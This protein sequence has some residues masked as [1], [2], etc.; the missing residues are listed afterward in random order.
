MKI[1]SKNE[2]IEWLRLHNIDFSQWG[3]ESAKSIEDLWHEIQMGESLIQDDPPCRVVLGVVRL[4]ICQEDRILIETKQE[5]GKN[6]CRDRNIPPSEKLKP[7]ESYIECAK[8]CLREE[9]GIEN[10]DMEIIESTY[11][12]KKNVRNSQSYPG[13]DTIYNNHKFKAIVNGLPKGSF[14]TFE[15]T[16][17][18]NNSIKKHYWTWIR[19]DKIDFDFI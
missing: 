11:S 8:R 3:R 2:L 5:F 7:L 9:L 15:S 17:K 6:Q 10:G 12:Q 14:S 18:D 13:L 1:K 16:H 19:E 4:I